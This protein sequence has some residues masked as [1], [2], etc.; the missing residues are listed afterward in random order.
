MKSDGLALFE[1]G[2]QTNFLTSMQY[3]NARNIVIRYKRE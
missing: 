1:R 3:Y 2:R